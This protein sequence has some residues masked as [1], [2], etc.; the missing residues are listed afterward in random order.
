M[1]LKQVL[2]PMDLRFQPRQIVYLKDQNSRLYA[3]IIQ[4]VESR[5][6][7]WVRPMM[8][9]AFAIDAFTAEPPLSVTDLRS[10]A[11][12]LLPSKLFQSALDT[13]VLPLLVGHLAIEPQSDRNPIALTQLHRFIHQVWQAYTAKGQKPPF[14]E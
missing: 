12:L 13:E 10:S 1:N 7:C 2:T 8:L 14:N 5:Q 6:V 11:D 9:V 3:E 4:V